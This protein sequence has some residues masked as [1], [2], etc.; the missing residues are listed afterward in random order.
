[1]IDKIYLQKNAKKKKNN[2]QM[3]N[4]LLIVP[5]AAG[6]YLKNKKKRSREHKKM[7]LGTRRI[8]SLHLTDFYYTE[9][10]N[11]GIM[12]T[13][14]V[15]VHVITFIAFKKLMCNICKLNEICGNCW[16]ESTQ[17]WINI[18]L[19]NKTF[20]RAIK[21]QDSFYWYSKR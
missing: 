8:I 16:L 7:R 2:K 20:Y 10:G 11:M 1:M 12:I 17:R 9:Y 15:Q 18:K 4:G 21:I 14:E 5:T 13:A 19:I 6:V 3:L